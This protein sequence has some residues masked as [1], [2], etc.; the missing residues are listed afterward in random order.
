MNEKERLVNRDLEIQTAQRLHCWPQSLGAQLLT[1]ETTERG[2]ER[3]E[4]HVK[5]ENTRN[6]KISVPQKDGKSVLIK[7]KEKT[8]TKTNKRKKTKTRK[9]KTSLTK[10]R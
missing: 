2:R 9:I 1:N 6:H 8:A 5:N 3:E 7:N 4:A 10:Y